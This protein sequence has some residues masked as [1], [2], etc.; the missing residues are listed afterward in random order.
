MICNFRHLSQRQIKIIS[1]VNL[2]TENTVSVKILIKCYGFPFCKTAIDTIKEKERSEYRNSFFNN[3]FL[4]GPAKSP[5]CVKEES[6]IC[7][8]VVKIF[9]IGSRSVTQMMM[10]SYT[11]PDAV[12]SLKNYTNEYL[13]NNDFYIYPEH[14]ESWMLFKYNHEL[15]S[16]ELY[17]W[18]DKIKEIFRFSFA[19]LLKLPPVS[20]CNVN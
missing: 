13:E 2:F 9:V 10:P 12:I 8:N 5:W 6:H 14:T 17:E 7:V 1:I 20:I 15:Q 19:L 16:Y 4:F 11:R 3:Y 18:F